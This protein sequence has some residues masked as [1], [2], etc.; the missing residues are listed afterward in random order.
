MIIDAG[1]GT[2]DLTTYKVKENYPLRLEREEI[3]PT[4]VLILIWKSNPY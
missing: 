4:G 1:G 2:V 3:E